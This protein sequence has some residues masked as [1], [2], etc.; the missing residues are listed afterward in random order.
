[1]TLPA[2]YRWLH[3]EPGPKILVEAL[4]T[5][6]V[7]EVPGKADNPEILRWAREVGVGTIYTHDSIA[8]CGLAV[9]YWCVKAGYRPPTNPLWARAWA[10]WGNEVATN[11]PMLG[12]IMVWERGSG[13]HVGMYIGEDDTHWHVLGGNQSDQVN[14]VRKAKTQPNG[15]RLIAVRRSP[16]KVGQPPNVRRVRLGAAGTPSSSSEA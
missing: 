5:H 1:M 14:I 11:R 15:S 4:R 13:G 10:K 12:D 9:A 6:G 2:K 16:F 8:W 3:Q 7:K